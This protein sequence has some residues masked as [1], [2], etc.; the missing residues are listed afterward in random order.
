MNN[1]NTLYTSQAAAIGRP[2]GLIRNA[3]TSQDIPGQNPAA[4]NSASAARRTGKLLALPFVIVTGILYLFC[5][6][7]VVVSGA[8]LGILSGIVLL[9]ALALFFAAGFWPGMSWLVG[10]F[11]E[12][13]IYPSIRIL[14]CRPEEINGISACLRNVRKSPQARWRLTVI[15]SIWI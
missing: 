2:Y 8:V 3:I 5:K 9:A 7:L 12:K 1:L 4:K 14:P 15:L 6:F 11:K 13:H 10:Y